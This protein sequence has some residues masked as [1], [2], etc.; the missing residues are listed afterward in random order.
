MDTLIIEGPQKVNGIVQVNGAKN[1][2]LPLMVCALLNQGQ[3]S[4]SNVPILTDVHTMVDLLRNYGASVKFDELSKKMI[5]NSSAIN[6]SYAPSA[7]VAKMR[8]SIWALAPIVSRLGYAKIALP[9]GDA[10]GDKQSGVR[11]IDLHTSLLEKMGVKIDYEGHYV[12]AK[13]DGRLKATEFH[14]PK[15]SVGA[16]INAVLACTL[17]DGESTIS[18]CAIEPEITDMCECLVKMGAKIDGIGTRTLIIKGIDKLLADVTH[19][20]IPDR[21]EAGTYL[22]MAAITK[23]KIRVNGINK[24]MLH[25]LCEKLEKSGSELKYF[26]NAIELT[27]SEV[28]VSVDIETEPFP[29]FVTDLQA[30]FMSLMSLSNA[31][32]YVVEN[33]YD[34]R[35]MHVRELNKMGANISTQD[36]KASIIGVQK[37]SGAVVHASDIRASVCLV[38]AALAADG[39]TTIHNAYHLFRGYEDLIG[40]LA[41]C[42]VVI[43]V[44]GSERI[45]VVA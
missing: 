30:Q 26:D 33:L 15:V 3:L 14:F 38:M 27:G 21:I 34:N 25:A 28:I 43:D 4:L 16:T 9:G 40:K 8:A 11:K 22:M 37:L 10:I 31:S 2:V 39:V 32:S 13:I 44:K 41:K 18:N 35:L 12:I 1:G 36:N 7:I 5:I 19:Q 6:N 23:G 29:G 20:V 45:A 24:N 42:Q 17:A